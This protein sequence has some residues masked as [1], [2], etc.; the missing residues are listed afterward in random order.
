[1]QGLCS[2]FIQF[3]MRSADPPVVVRGLDFLGDDGKA[4]AVLA[5]AGRF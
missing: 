3:I 2:S 1:M 4:Q 5:G